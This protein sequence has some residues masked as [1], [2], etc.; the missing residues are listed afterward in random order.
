MLECKLA[1]PFAKDRPATAQNAAPSRFGGDPDPLQSPAGRVVLVFTP[2]EGAGTSDRT[3]A[4]CA[5]IVV[6]QESMR[7]RVVVAVR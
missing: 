6:E 5:A 2:A 7:L 4:K 1:E 3:L